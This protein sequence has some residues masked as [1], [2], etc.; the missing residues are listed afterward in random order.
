MKLEK[1]KV[2]SLLIFALILSVSLSN[3]VHA[4]TII[5]SS[6]SKRIAS[7]NSNKVTLANGSKVNCT[8]LSGICIVGSTMYCVKIN[9]DNNAAIL[10][11]VT[12]YNTSSAKTTWKVI[13]NN[14]GKVDQTLGHV[15]GMTYY[16][17]YFYLATGTKKK[18]VKVNKSGRV[19]DSYA[20]AS[21]IYSITYSKSG[22]FI[23]GISNSGNYKRYAVSKLENGKVD[24]KKVFYV[25]NESDCAS[26]DI[27]F[28]N[29]NFYI[30]RSYKNSAGHLNKNKI[31]VL[32]LSKI[33]VNEK[34]YSPYQIITS[35]KTSVKKYE[36]ESLDLVNGKIIA[37]ANYGTTDGTGV[38]GVFQINV[39]K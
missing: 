33:I 37:C 39:N 5:S 11:T 30:I 19:V 31:L 17:G 15:N 27:K 3:S 25:L 22:F 26:Q 28:S 1:K 16:N 12:N 23:V 29:G 4:A 14:K 9:G 13:T 32:D 21:P 2:F 18:V 7:I 36:L 6:T 34:V 35:N 38:D 24:Q 20:S 8:N 10:Y